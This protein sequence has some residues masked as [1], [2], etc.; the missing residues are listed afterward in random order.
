MELSSKLQER[1]SMI[2]EA[3][4]EALKLGEQPR[5]LE[6]MRHLPIAGGKRLRPALVM[7][8]TEAV[9]GDSAKSLPFGISLE[10]IH[11]FTLVHDDIMDQ[12]DLRRGVK[13]VHNVYGQ[14]SAIN[15]GDALLARAFEILATIELENDKLVNL[16]HEVAR[17]VRQLG[18]GQ[19]SDL[20]FEDQVEIT[21][22]EYLGMI[23]KKTGLMF[24]MAAKGGAIIGNGSDEQVEA[25]AE[26]G[27]LL[28]IGF[29]IWDDVL[30]IKRSKDMKSYGSD[31]KAGKKTL[32]MVYALEH[33]SGDDKVQLNQIVGNRTA[34]DDDINLAIDILN[35]SGAV[36]YTQNLAEEYADKARQLLKVLPESE[37]KKILEE[38]VEFMVKRDF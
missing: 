21:A 15:A 33:A 7:L 8:I 16:I 24:M 25:M 29:Q 30:D 19:Q 2:D 37:S 32:M 31:I 18:E 4:D 14:S 6:A 11:N 5:L 27:R 17:M 22:D 26:Y 13:T 1:I 3:L 20:D 28:G 9:N 12:D 10:I 35:R 38:F 36:D 34:S 23:E